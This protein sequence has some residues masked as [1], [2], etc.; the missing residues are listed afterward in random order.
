MQ[1]GANPNHYEIAPRQAMTPERYQ[2]P[3]QSSEADTS[4]EVI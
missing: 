1:R 2:E 3:T 4:K